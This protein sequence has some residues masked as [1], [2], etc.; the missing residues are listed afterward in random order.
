MNAAQRSPETMRVGL[1]ILVVAPE[2][3][4]LESPPLLAEDQTMV[5]TLQGPMLQLW[6]TLAL[7]SVEAAL[8][9]KALSVIER[10]RQ[11][12]GGTA[13]A[14]GHAGSISGKENSRGKGNTKGSMR[15]ELGKAKGPDWGTGTKQWQRTVGRHG[16]KDGWGSGTQKGQVADQEC[17]EARG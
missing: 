1:Q 8:A 9:G 5:S 10:G 3:L 11:S 17:G 13:F 4:K 16:A 12:G 15:M 2:A 14:G 6:N 7:S